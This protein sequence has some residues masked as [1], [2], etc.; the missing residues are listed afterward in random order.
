MSA[1]TRRDGS[2]G[3]DDGRLGSGGASTLLSLGGVRGWVTEMF[4][5]TP[6]HAVN[7]VNNSTSAV[8]A[9]VRGDTIHVIKDD[10]VG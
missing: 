2:W 1:V 4:A 6:L 8:P 5:V 9:V 10:G 3:H 7:V